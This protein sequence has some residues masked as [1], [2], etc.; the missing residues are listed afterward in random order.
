[1][2]KQL[3]KEGRR[4]VDVLWASFFQAAAAWPSFE[5]RGS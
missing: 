3:N 2:L 4:R 1:M 5:S